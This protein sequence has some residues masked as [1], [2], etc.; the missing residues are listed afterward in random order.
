MKP[1]KLGIAIN[2]KQN[3]ALH[4]VLHTAKLEAVSEY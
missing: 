4:N 2:T 1:C 3:D